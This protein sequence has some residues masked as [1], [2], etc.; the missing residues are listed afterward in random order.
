M[1]DDVDPVVVRAKIGWEREVGIDGME[2][3]NCAEDDVARLHR[4]R[5]RST[6]EA[7][8]TAKQLFARQK[9]R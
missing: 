2:F 7:F 8:E 5:V 4:C 1:V 3:V 9:S 6:K